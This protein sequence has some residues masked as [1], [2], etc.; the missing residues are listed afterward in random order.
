[1]TASP[2]WKVALAVPAQ[3]GDAFAQTV[4]P[5]VGAFSMFEIS[6]LALVICASSTRP[7]T[8]GAT[9][10]AVQAQI[11]TMLQELSGMD[12]ADLVTHRREK[13]LTMGD[14]GLAA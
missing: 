13:F 11:R 14:K 12:R 10:A 9:I 5:F 4:E 1:M 3:F 7:M 2:V 8:F 6:A